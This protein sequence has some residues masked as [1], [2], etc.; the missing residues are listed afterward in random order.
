MERPKKQIN[1][2]ITIG[3]IILLIFPKLIVPLVVIVIGWY[4][5]VKKGINFD[6]QNASPMLGKIVI[7]VVILL[8][9]VS[10]LFKS[11]IVISPGKTGVYQ[12]FGTVSDQEL[13]SGLH[14]VN[15]LSQVT[16]LS[17]RTE[18]YT[19][20]IAVG[21]G[22]RTQADA[23]SA[24]TKEGLSVDLDITVLYHLLE[25][26]ASDVYK[27]VGLDFDEKII[28]PEIRSA[29][30]EVVAQYDAK[31]IYSDKRKE[32]AMKILDELK[33]KIEPRGVYV[34]E[35]LLR[36]VD[37]PAKL[38][39]SIQAKLTA[40]QDAQRMEFILE[41]EKKEAERKVIEAQGQKDSQ[42]IISESL[43]DRYLEY[44]YINSLKDRQGTIYVPV[45]P[46]TGMPLFKSIP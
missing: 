25:D 35:V 39:E 28:R 41:K 40:D 16:Q 36:N 17:T 22:R 2:L 9:L 4:I 42:K 45:N 1:T 43:T 21:E 10:L 14:F 6:M 5:L 32:T 26:K 24:L 15:P 11:F 8:V 7:L 34:E 30:R 29:I 12:L 46:Q 38:T 31:E 23:I 44:L 18:E 20:S 19:M 33:T 27:T 3:L 37:L 13:K